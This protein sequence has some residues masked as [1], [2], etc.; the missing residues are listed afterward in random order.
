MRFLKYVQRHSC[1]LFD[2]P[3]P[4]WSRRRLPPGGWQARPPRLRCVGDVAPRPDA[5]CPTT[6]EA[7]PARLRLPLVPCRA[8]PTLPLHG[9]HAG[10]GGGGLGSRASTVLPPPA[11]LPIA[12]TNLL[13]RWPSSRLVAPVPALPARLC[14]PLRLRHHGGAPMAVP[15]GAPLSSPLPAG[16]SDAWRSPNRA[17]LSPLVVGLPRGRSVPLRMAHAGDCRCPIN[18]VAV[19]RRRWWPEGI[20]AIHWQCSRP[21][22]QPSTTAHNIADDAITSP[23]S[24]S[25][26]SPRS[27][28]VHHFSSSPPLTPTLQGRHGFFDHRSHLRLLLSR[29]LP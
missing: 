26:L 14:Q 8:A 28:T 5:T 19:A 9:P 16:T 17:P 4:S 2:P 12:P 13:C 15:D 3:L 18:R 27:P 23:T 25:A 29:P 24:Y 6:D 21:S 20:K 1:P 10:S 11:G 22:P 7:P